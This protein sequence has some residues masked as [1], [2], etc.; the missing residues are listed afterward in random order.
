M[1]S[2]DWF[3]ALLGRVLNPPIRPS[4]QS[5]SGFNKICCLNRGWWGI[6]NSMPY[7]PIKNQG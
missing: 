4:M 3:I 2:A 1:H 5:F 7:D 6:C